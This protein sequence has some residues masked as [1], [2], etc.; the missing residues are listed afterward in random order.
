MSGFSQVL[1]FLLRNVWA[2]LEARSNIQA[3]SQLW[4]SAV[5][6]STACLL[7]P[8]ILFYISGSVWIWT[9]FSVPMK[10]AVRHCWLVW[11]VKLQLRSSMFLIPSLSSFI[12]AVY[13][14]RGR[15]SPNSPWTRW[16][17]QMIQLTFSAKCTETRLQLS[18]GGE[19]RESCP[20]AG[21][22]EQT[23]MYSCVR[24]ASQ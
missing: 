22:M 6:F 5:A 9:N 14:Q 24:A 1:V 2:S 10:G 4:C 17:W 3:E 11:K 23:L 13:F 20:G 19:R 8:E 7:A 15:Y 16:C 12:V 21:N 18:A